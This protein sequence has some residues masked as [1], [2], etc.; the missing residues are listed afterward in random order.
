MTFPGFPGAFYN[1]AGSFDQFFRVQLTAAGL[2]DWLPSAVVNYDFPQKALTFP[3]WSVTHL[4]TVPR[5]IAQGRNLDPGWKGVEQIGLADIRC[6]ESV[7][8]AQGAQGRN[9]RQMRDMASRIFATGA[10]IPVLDVY[11]STANPTGNGTIIR[12]SPL[13]EVGLGPD[14]NPDITSVRLMAEYRYL[15]RATAG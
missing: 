11:G 9:L 2:P 4:G 5:E 6:W 15:E 1:V 10:A 7:R 3:S 14:P 12:I 8:R 13:R